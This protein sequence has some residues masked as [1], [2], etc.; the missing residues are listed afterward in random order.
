MDAGAEAV[1]VPSAFTSATGPDHWEVLLRA[2]AIENQIFVIAP[3]QFGKHGPNLQSYGRS[4]IVDPWGV[5]LATASDGVGL[6]TAEIDLAVLVEVRERL[7]ALKNRRP[8]WWS[9]Q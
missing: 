2:R 1:A 6:V 4:M 7:P 3:N 5:V 9:R 8:E